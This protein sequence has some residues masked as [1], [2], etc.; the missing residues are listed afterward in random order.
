MQKPTLSPEILAHI[1]VYLPCIAEARL[2][3]TTK[4]LA[5][6][7]TETKKARRLAVLRAFE[8]LIAHVGDFPIET[9][10]PNRKAYSTMK[11][12]EEYKMV[13]MERTTKDKRTGLHVYVEVEWHEDFLFVHIRS[14]S[15]IKCRSSGE[16]RDACIIY[17][18]KGTMR[19]RGRASVEQPM[20]YEDLFRMLDIML[21]VGA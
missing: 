9:E 8:T 12:S 2:L 1:C 14:T 15:S 17:P 16:D 3:M 20:Q 13:Q 19:K 21:S 11:Y 5:A 6:H 10:V 4:R 7:A 18:H